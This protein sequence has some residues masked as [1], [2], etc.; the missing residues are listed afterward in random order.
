MSTGL[1]RLSYLEGTTMKL[2]VYQGRHGELEL[3]ND[4]ATARAQQDEDNGMTV[5]EILEQGDLEVG[6]SEE[7]GSFWIDEGG[8]ITLVQV[9]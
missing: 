8:D 6:G 2:W 1:P 7:E 3:Y 4:F 5:E 9:P